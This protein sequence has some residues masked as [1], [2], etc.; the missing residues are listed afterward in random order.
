MMGRVGGGCAVF[1][2]FNL[3]L[4]HFFLT[5]TATNTEC[6]GNGVVSSRQAHPGLAVLIA[7]LDAPSSTSAGCILP[8]TIAVYVAVNVSAAITV[9]ADNFFLLALLVNCCLCPLSLL[10]SLLSSLPPTAIALV[11]YQGLQLNW[12]K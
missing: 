8:V 4:I 1:L 2:N 5:V 11:N 6:Q 10:L 3:I 9:T 7:V 12:S